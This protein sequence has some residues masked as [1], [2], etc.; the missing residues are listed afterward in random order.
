MKMTWEEAVTWAKEAKEMQPL[1]QNCYY[2]DPIE[3]SARRF[4][5]SEEWAAIQEILNFSPEDR[6]LDVGAGRNC[7]EQEHPYILL[8]WNAIN[9]KAYDCQSISLLNFAIDADYQLVSLPY[10]L[11]ITDI[12]FLELHMIQTEN[13]LLIPNQKHKEYEE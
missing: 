11:P 9:L 10:L 4:Y 2:D 6:V 5:E 13:F 3:S 12:T 1:V 8:E 7:L